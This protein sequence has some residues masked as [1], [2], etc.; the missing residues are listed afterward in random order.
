MMA[1]TKLE[2]NRML[3]ILLADLCQVPAEIDQEVKGLCAD[4]RNVQPGDLFFACAG[5]T[6][7]GLEF[8]EAA[9]N[10][11]AEIILWE[12]SPN[13][14]SLPLSWRES[15]DGNRIPLL[16]VPQLSLQVG[17]IAD[18]F[19]G[20]PSTQ[21]F[22]VGITGTNGKT[23]CSQFL[24][25][26]LTAKGQCGVIGTLGRGLHGKLD[27]TQHTTPDALTC[28][29]LLA[30]MNE[31]GAKNAVMEVSSHALDQGRV[32]AVAFNC[33]VF[34]N[35]SRDHL[36]YHGDMES[37]G[38]AKRKLFS[39]PGLE[40]AVINK[41]D[42]FGE[43]LIQTLPKDIKVMSYG[44]Q[45]SAD[46]IASDI[47]LSQTGLCCHVTTPMGEGELKASILGRF[48]ISNL[49]AVLGVLLLK[50]ESLE[51][52]LSDLSQVKPVPGR[53]ECVVKA[54]APLIV[55]DYAHT[56]DALEQVL[57]AVREHCENKLICVFGCGGDR[58]QGKR[59]IMG[60]IADQYAD[61][62]IL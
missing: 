37:Y 8:V 18:R 42:D 40:M 49:L 24:A 53:M 47:T 59:S 22:T 51:R 9:I 27:E 31:A 26:V 55:I 60:T 39:F 28:H 41:D 11:G 21:M 3:S 29:R 5:Q 46:I 57:K 19:Y 58:D 61:E 15:P 36:D 35:L 13:I 2:Q 45:K 12:A 56:P 1:A 34:T 54:G 17:V 32:N 14:E 43:T 6:V 52:A 10:A 44:M 50:G 7:H 48:N 62:I 23:S 38:E 30:D 16:A 33:A 20:Q 25:D 4:S